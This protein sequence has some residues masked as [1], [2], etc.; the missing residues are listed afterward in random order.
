MKCHKADLCK[1]VANAVHLNTNEKKKIYELLLKYKDLFNGTLIEWKMDLVDFEMVEDAKLHSQ[2]H[3][4]V[5]RLYKDTLKKEIDRLV[6]LG[7]LEPIQESEWGSLTFIIQ[8]QICVRFPKTQ[9]KNK[10]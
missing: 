3:Y 2:R 6:D 5:P 9:C 1:V 4:P 10:V 7:V 8:K